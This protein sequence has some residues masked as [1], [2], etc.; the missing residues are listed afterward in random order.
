MKFTSIPKAY[1]SYLEPLVYEFDTQSEA[2]DVEARII[3]VAT[4]EVIGRKMLYG[5][6][7][8]QIDIAPYL[9]RV[10]KVELP[11]K[12]EYSQMLETGVQ[13]KVKVEVAG[14]SSSSRNFIA[15]KLPSSTYFALLTNQISRRT[16]AR[17]EFDIVAF[18][19]SPDAVVEILVEV[20]GKSYGY[21]TLEHAT[22]G[23]S[24]VA[25]TP[26][27]FDDGPEQMKLSIKVDGS[28]MAEVE[29]ELKENLRGAR[30]LA[31]LNA[32]RSPELYTFPMRKSILIE[33]ARRHIESMWGREAAEIEHEGELKLLSAYEPQAQLGAIAEIHN[34]EKVWLVEGAEV[35][36]VELKSERVMTLPC[37]EM[38]LV[39]VDICA[40]EEGVKLW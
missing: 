14:V 23:Q 37:D 40:A 35:N 4:N 28:V 34:S 30:R 9:R 2:A 24:A 18:Y 17:D 38:G 26:L 29:Y 8:G 32:T 5:V 11:E 16:M 6:S 22:G 12:I 36:R 15:A 10:A 31:W 3:N 21:L 7:V 33:A 27:D 1:S 13:I 19:S 39:E 20:W 25:V